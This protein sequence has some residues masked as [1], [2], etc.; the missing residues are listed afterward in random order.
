MIT[1]MVKVITYWV[2]F[3]GIYLLLTHFAKAQ[4]III[5]TKLWKEELG[6]TINSMEIEWRVIKNSF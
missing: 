6:R 2:E 5:K 4:F 3:K 1:F